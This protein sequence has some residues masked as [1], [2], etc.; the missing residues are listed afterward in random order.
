[1]KLD[2]V[3]LTD[4]QKAFAEALREF[5]R[6]EAGTRARRDEL[7]EHGRHAHHQGSTRRWPGSAGSAPAA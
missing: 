1:M 6:R 2:L 4:E 7:T 5:S 3:E